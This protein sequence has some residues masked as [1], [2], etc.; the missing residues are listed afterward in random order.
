MCHQNHKCILCTWN[1]STQQKEISVT[2]GGT[3]NVLAL[4]QQSVLCSP[5][6]I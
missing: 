6:Y 1:T 3:K 5:I 4:P 2:D